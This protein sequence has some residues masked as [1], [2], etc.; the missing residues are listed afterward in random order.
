MYEK[1]KNKLQYQGIL[2]LGEMVIMIE[3]NQPL[4]EMKMFNEQMIPSE[5][6]KIDWKIV[7]FYCSVDSDLYRQSLQKKSSVRNSYFNRGYYVCDHFGSPVNMLIKENQIIILGESFERI[8][9]SYIV[10][11]L[12][13]LWAIENN[14]VFVKCA[15]FE[16]KGEATLLIGRGGS[17]KTV[18]NTCVCKDRGN[19]ITNSNAF[20]KDGKILG[21]GS[22]IRIRD[23]ECYKSLLQTDEQKNGLAEGEILINPYKEF[24]CCCDEWYSIKNI[25]MV[26]YINGNCQ[27][28]KLSVNECLSYAEEFMLG[29]NVY[30]LE[31]D[32]LDY[33]ESDCL[34]FVKYYNEMKQEMTNCIEK[35]Q[36]YYADFDIIDINV[37]K[38][39]FEKL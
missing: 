23:K 10:K 2:K 33:C 14:A 3:S 34:K 24:H 16:Y 19:F 27:L 13:Q 12:M 26:N 9:W 21:I 38:E 20:I 11:Y 17:G 1:I 35:S 30:R 29:I 28:Q 18:I 4:L 6:K 8:L 36:C 25:I 22:N 5:V 32:I 37:R 31:E 15:A 7:L 39:L